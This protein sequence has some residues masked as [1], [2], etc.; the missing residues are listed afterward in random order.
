[1]LNETT[2]ALNNMGLVLH[3]A[4]RQADAFDAYQRAL[5][6]CGACLCGPHAE[7]A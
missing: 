2:D 1:V 3:E 5:T 7:R 4:G 6:L